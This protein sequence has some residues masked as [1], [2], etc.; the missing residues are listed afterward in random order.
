MTTHR[1]FRTKAICNFS[2]TVSIDMSIV[3]TQFSITITFSQPQL[4]SGF[5]CSYYESSVLQPGPF[6]NDDCVKIV[7]FYKKLS[8]AAFLFMLL[9]RNYKSIS[10]N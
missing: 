1:I 6:L 10:S 7:D 9:A 8:Y 2:G 4:L 5:L 3:F